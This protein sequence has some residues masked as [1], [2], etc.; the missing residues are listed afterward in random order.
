MIEQDI[1]KLAEKYGV[2]I[3]GT[4]KSKDANLTF[5]IGQIPK[6]E[7]Q[8]SNCKVPWESDHTCPGALQMN[9]SSKTR[10]DEKIAT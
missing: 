8:C 9:A 2:E 10:M 1:E 7:R 4:V 6:V 5:S 3:H